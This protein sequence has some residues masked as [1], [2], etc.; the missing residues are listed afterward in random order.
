VSVVLQLR[1]LVHASDC[2]TVARP[3]SLA[4][5]VSL[6]SGTRVPKLARGHLRSVA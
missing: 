3:G 1:R 6:S 5:R 4:L 2:S